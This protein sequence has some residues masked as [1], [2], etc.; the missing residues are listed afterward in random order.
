MSEGQ[1]GTWAT[2]LRWPDAGKRLVWLAQQAEQSRAGTGSC[3]LLLLGRYASMELG[4]LLVLM[5]PAS[6]HCSVQSMS[7]SS[8]LVLAVQ[9]AYASNCA[10]LE[11]RNSSARIRP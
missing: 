3:H 7:R 5:G 8:A 6:K 9:R 4:A 11:Q 10:R 1:Q 2:Q